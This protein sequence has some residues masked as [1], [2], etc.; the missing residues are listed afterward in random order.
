MIDK[1]LDNARAAGHLDSVTCRKGCSQ[2]CKYV[3]V[4]KDEASLLYQYTKENHIHIDQD[5][6]RKQAMLGSNVMDWY[7]LMVMND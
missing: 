5:K 4:T 2:C 3:T 6:L 1:F 7:A